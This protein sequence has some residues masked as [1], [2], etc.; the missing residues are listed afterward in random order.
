MRRK[1]RREAR[2]LRRA[3]KAK[4]A[5]EQRIIDAGIAILVGDGP[6]I[7]LHNRRCEDP[8]CDLPRDHTG[9]CYRDLLL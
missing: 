6:H 5:A 4:Q 2:A 8:Y 1:R 3:R 9:P 7:P